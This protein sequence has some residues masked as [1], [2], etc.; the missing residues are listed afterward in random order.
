MD[1]D[2]QRE[3][4]RE[5]YKKNKKKKD[6]KNKTWAQKP[7]N[8]A[9]RV[10]YVQNYVK[11]NK[12]KVAKYNK[13]Y[14]MSLDGRYR[15]LKYRHKKRR[16]DDA[17]MSKARFSELFDMPCTYCGGQTDGGIDRKDNLQGYSEKNSTPCCE[18]CNHMK[19]KLTQEQFLNHIKKICQ[20]H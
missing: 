8:K 13:Y 18:W 3:Y 2:K 9:K 7:E 6:A 10:K 5:W 15:L 14:G 11:R 1:K 20:N 17:V 19:W 16:W 12:K 4:H